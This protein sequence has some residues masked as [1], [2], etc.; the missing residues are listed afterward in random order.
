MPPA[1]TRK[2]SRVYIKTD[3]VPWFC[4][5]NHAPIMPTSSPATGFPAVHVLTMV[6]IPPSIKFRFRVGDES[7]FICKNHHY[8]P[9]PRRP[10]WRWKDF[11]S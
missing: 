7:R 5:T 4:E 11:R 10:P 2:M 8:N 9:Q 1:V 6:V 3:Y